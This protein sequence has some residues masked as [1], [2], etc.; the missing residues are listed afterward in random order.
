MLQNKSQTFFFG[1]KNNP[2]YGNILGVSRR[3]GG[4]S[5]PFQSFLLRRKGKEKKYFHF[6]L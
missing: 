6:N 4:P 2:I 1:F 5:F 3:K